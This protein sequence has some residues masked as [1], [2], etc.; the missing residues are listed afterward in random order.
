M[1]L[2]HIE[3]AQN[4]ITVLCDEAYSINRYGNTIKEHAGFTEIRSGE[5]LVGIKVE[6]YLSKKEKFGLQAEEAF[7]NILEKNKI[8]ALHIGQ[9]PRGVDYSSVLKRDNKARR[10]DFLVSLPD[11]GTIF[12][13][14]KCRRKVSFFD[15][16]N[17]YFYLENEEVEELLNLQKNLLIPVWIAFIDEGA[18]FRKS[19]VIFETVSI[20]AIDTYRQQVYSK[21]PDV[22]FY[23]VPTELVTV[24][25]PNE[26][27][28]FSI[29]ANQHM[30]WVQK[31]TDLYHAL[32]RITKEHIN[33]T[34]RE[35]EDSTEEEILN[36]LMAKLGEIILKPEIK[37][38]ISIQKR[39]QD[40]V[41]KGGKLRLRGEQKQGNE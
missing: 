20:K 36:K 7:K 21:Y 10:P 5:K 29:G 18:I 1:S 4:T 40:I 15:D 11:L 13:D 37:H 16:V 30:G 25:K 22:R 12:I 31:Y 24:Q 14:V 35:C 28:C 19:N 9:G 8:P 38:V 23:R 39:S 3:L 27:L 33:H 17:K 32:F 41:E 34:I 2:S 6:N 26:H